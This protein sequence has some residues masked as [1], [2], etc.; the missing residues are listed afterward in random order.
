MPA[1]EPAF[2][3]GRT[4]RRAHEIRQA[5]ELVLAVEHERG[6]LLVRQHVLTEGRGERSEPLVDLGEPRLRRRCERCARPLVHRVVAFEHA[7]LLGAERKLA[8][9][10]VQRLDAAK[11]RRIHEDPVPMLGLKR[12]QFA[13]DRENGVVGIGVRK[14]VEDIGDA[15]EQLPGALDRLDGIDEGRRRR[16]RGNG[17]D[18]GGMVG[19]C[20]GEGGEEMLR[21]DACERRHAEGPGPVLQ[22]GIIA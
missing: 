20:P 16:V 12:R 18:F 17:G 5:D 9:R 8:A 3:G 7:L 13:L 2:R 4:R 10:M 19:K 22:H 11:Q 14:R 21:R 1:V 6:R 15:R